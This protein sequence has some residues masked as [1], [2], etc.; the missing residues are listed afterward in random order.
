MGNNN[1]ILI[2]KLI[3]KSQWRRIV[4]AISVHGCIGIPTFDVWTQ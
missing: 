4:Y 2:W 1:I 3:N